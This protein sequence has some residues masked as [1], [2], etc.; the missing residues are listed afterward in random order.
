MTADV[1]TLLEQW[2]KRFSEYAERPDA[3]PNMDE[4]GQ[5]L[6]D[7]ADEINGLREDNKRLEQELDEL[8]WTRPGG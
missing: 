5:L 3:P 1:V 7:A 2:A 6:A 4:L 8:S